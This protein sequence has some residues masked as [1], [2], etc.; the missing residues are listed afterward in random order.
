MEVKKKNEREGPSLHFPW[1]SNL[2]LIS[3]TIVFRL[4]KI[5]ILPFRRV[6]V[7]RIKMEALFYV[8]T[9]LVYVIFDL[10]EVKK[11]SFGNE[12]MALMSHIIIVILKILAHMQF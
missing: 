3:I 10:N 5:H 4:I 2:H 12:G 1:L 6:M 7:N 8:P 9:I 11:N